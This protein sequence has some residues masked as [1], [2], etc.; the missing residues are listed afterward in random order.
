MCDIELVK[1]RVGD[2][3]LMINDSVSKLGSTE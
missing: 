3:K 1:I 2:L